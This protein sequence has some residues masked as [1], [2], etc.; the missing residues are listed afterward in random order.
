MTAPE[1]F[2]REFLDHRRALVAWC[3][4]IAAYVG[5][6]AAIFPSIHGSVQFDRLVEGYPDALKALF[7][8]QGGSITTG[9]GY[10]DVELFSL[11]LPLLV[12]VLAIGAGARTFAGEEEAGRLELPL[13]YPVRRSTVV[14]WKGLAVSVEIA[15]AVLAA[16]VAIVVLDP[17]VGLDL[18]MVNLIEAV[19]ALAILGILFGWTA[20]AV[21]AA[22]PSRALAIGVPAGIAAAG[23]LVGG[24]HSL[25]PWLDPFRFVSPFWLVGTGPLRNGADLVGVMI[26]AA[27]AICVLLIGAWRAEKRDLQ[28]P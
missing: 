6:I 3:V 5:L 12:L 26:V 11:M 22:F 16:G 10:L 14:A 2:R 17:V 13:S 23:Y 18:S 24:L 27:V 8:L 21:G 15:A 19:V 1:A 7:G 28:T 4:G 9:A 25:A 20:L